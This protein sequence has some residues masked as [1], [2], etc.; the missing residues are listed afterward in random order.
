MGGEPTKLL[1]ASWQAEQEIAATAG[2]L[3][4]VPANVVKLVVE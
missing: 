2:W 3:I 1:P 4:A